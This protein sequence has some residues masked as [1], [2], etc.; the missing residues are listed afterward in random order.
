MTEP[1][2]VWVMPPEP[3]QVWVMPLQQEDLVPLPAL[4]FRPAADRRFLSF[5][6]RHKKVFLPPREEPIIEHYA[7]FEDCRAQ[8]LIVKKGLLEQL[9]ARTRETAQIIEHLR[10]IP[11]ADFPDVIREAR[12]AEQEQEEKAQGRQEEKAQA[13]Q[14]KTDPKRPSRRN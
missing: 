12:E 11:T 7:T 13:E 14:V 5:Y 10:T 3:E 6:D 2:Q 4:S 1:Q 9:H 8:M